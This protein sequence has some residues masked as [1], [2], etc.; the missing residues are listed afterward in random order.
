M[1]TN[2]SSNLRQRGARE[3]Y[4]RVTTVTIFWGSTERSQLRRDLG[5]CWS[6]WRR[7][8]CK[9]AWERVGTPMK[10]LSVT[11]AT[12]LCKV[13]HSC[14]GDGVY[15]SDWLN[16]HSILFDR[17]AVK[18]RADRDIKPANILVSHEGTTKIADFGLARF[19]LETDLTT[20]YVGTTTFLSPERLAGQPYSY[21]SDVWSFGLSVL[22]IC[23]GG[24]QSIVS[25]EMGY[26][27]VLNIVTQTRIGLPLDGRVVMKN[28]EPDRLFS[29]DLVDFID[30]CLVKSAQDRATAAELLTHPFI[31]SWSRR[32]KRARPEEF[33]LPLAEGSPERLAAEAIL[34]E[35]VQRM[36]EHLIA[37]ASRAPVVVTS[38]PEDTSQHRAPVVGAVPNVK[39]MELPPLGG[40]AAQLRLPLATVE[41]AFNDFGAEIALAASNATS[42]R[43]AEHLQ[44]LADELSAQQ[45]QGI[46]L[47]TGAVVN[48]PAE[49]SPPRI[50]SQNTQQPAY[51][52]LSAPANGG[53]SSLEAPGVLMLRFKFA[54]P[55]NV[56]EDDAEAIYSSP[57]NSSD[58]KER[59]D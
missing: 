44:T 33:K 30:C 21:Q 26:L 59:R 29:R 12:V 27:K 35:T 48:L 9:T 16:V 8:R 57:P 13:W 31:T 41:A 51:C 37:L 38:I 56:D 22:S 17:L 45:L 34:R 58:E 49:L 36:T 3:V 43:K 14:T 4:R 23:I 7:A 40:L 25:N 39:E 24:L 55:I 2:N 19:M 32:T 1:G 6:I 54:K 18:L 53:S 11:H 47:K 50:F 15:V 42:G 5:S 20:S 46:V 28:G 10:M 52:G